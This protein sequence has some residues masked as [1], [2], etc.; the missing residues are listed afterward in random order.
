VSRR[1]TLP[2]PRHPTAA[3]ATTAALVGILALAGCGSSGD[4]DG[5]DTV[6]VLAAASLQ[7]SFEALADEFEAD[8][9]GADIQLSFG[10]SSGLAEQIVAGAPADVFASASPATM[11]TVEDARLAVDPADLAV[12]VGTIVVPPGNPAGITGVA[13]LADPDVKVAVC[14]QD[15][16]CGTVATKVFE[17]A[18]IS[19]TPVTQE[20]DVKA[21][22]T[23][24]TTDAVDAGIVYRT[25]ATAAGDAVLEVPLTGDEAVLTTYRITTLKDSSDLAADFVAYVLS[26]AGQHVLAEAGFGPPPS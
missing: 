19:V 1:T 22:L 2:R 11:Q 4:S 15:V 21:V 20:T 14:Q 13:D 12:N 8:H 16:P 9:D 26:D 17:A 5:S 10:G 3:A 23:K 18:G 7:E 25:D 6:V 24:V